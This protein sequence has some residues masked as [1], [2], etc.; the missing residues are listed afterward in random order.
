MI[1]ISL[2]LVLDSLLPS[3]TT[4]FYW[5]WST[6]LQV[7]TWC[8]VATYHYL[9]QRCLIT[10]KVR[11]NL[12][13]GD[14]SSADISTTSHHNQIE[15]DFSKCSF[16]SA[17]GQWDSGPPGHCLIIWWR[18][19]METFSELPAICVG[20][21]PVTGEFPLQRPYKGQWHGALVFSLICPWLNG[22]VNNR[23]AGDLRCH[24]AHYDVIVMIASCCLPPR[25]LKSIWA[26][27]Y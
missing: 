2:K 3:D 27:Y 7:M 11:W 16:K 1:Q 10:S 23:E 13:K 20:N 21:S 19:Q 12:S 26:I 18:H 8:L 4:W 14:F 15:N 17:R 6:L 24:R 9:N 25:A 5:I 22:W